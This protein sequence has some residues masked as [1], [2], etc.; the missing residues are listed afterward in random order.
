MLL[1]KIGI[2][3]SPMKLD[4]TMGEATIPRKIEYIYPCIFSK[5]AI[6]TSK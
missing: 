3:K 1:V 5:E 4:L 6:K 2:S